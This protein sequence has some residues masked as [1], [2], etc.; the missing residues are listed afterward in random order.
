MNALTILV[1]ARNRDDVLTL[2]AVS[3]VFALEDLNLTLQA[4]FA[5]TL[6]NA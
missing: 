4:Y 2:W 5:L 3:D 6:M 1:F